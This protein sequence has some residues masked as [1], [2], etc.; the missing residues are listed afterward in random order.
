MLLDKIGMFCADLKRNLK[1]RARLN[2]AFDKE[3]NILNLFY[4]MFK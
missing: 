4:N 2:Y 3:V 1:K